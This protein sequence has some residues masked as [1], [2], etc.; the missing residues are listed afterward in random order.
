MKNA[1]R[2]GK[3][4]VVVGCVT[5]DVRLFDVPKLKVCALKVTESARAR[6][7]KAGGEVITFDQLAMRSPKG[8]KTVLLQGMLALHNFLQISCAPI[9]VGLL[10]SLISSLSR[11]TQVT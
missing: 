11:T 6:I 5:N 10:Y 1:E 9:S 3:T 7:V 4:A 2:D 8:Q